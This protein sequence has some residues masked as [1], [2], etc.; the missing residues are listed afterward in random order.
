MRCVV[1]GV[2]DGSL[3]KEAPPPFRVVTKV[4]VESDVGG[5]GLFWCLQSSATAKNQKPMLAQEKSW[6]SWY[7][8]VYGGCR[9]MLI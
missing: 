6:V 1:L 2:R 8:R 7:V 5:R 4:V 3:V 9:A